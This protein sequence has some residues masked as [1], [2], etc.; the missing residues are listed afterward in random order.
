VKDRTLTLFHLAEMDFKTAQSL[1]EEIPSQAAFHAQQCAEKSL[2]EVVWELNE[3]EDE[4][5]LRARIKHDSIKAVTR[6]MSQMIRRSMR[7]SGYQGLEGRLRK[8]GNT[9]AG[10][11]ALLLYLASSAAFDDVFELFD[12]LPISKTKDYW[13]ESLDSNL[14]PDP[15]FDQ[16]WANQLRRAGEFM[17]LLMEFLFSTMN[18]KGAGKLSEVASNPARLQHALQTA[19]NDMTQKGQGDQAKALST[20]MDVVNRLT[21][22]DA[23]FIQWGKNVMFWAP[24]LDAHAVRGRYPTSKEL[25]KYMK[26]KEGV[27]N[28]VA[29]SKEIMDQS[30]AILPLLSSWR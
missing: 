3:T 22:Q 6:V 30:K 19:L 16:K 10:K 9:E 23:S 17:D 18:V 24:Y 1:V 5:E 20:A 13:G 8:Q 21:N 28:L 11:L 7:R 12:R 15:S 29:K 26:K 4:D 27:S 14:Q 25:K 2:K